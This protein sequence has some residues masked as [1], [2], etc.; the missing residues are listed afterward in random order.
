MTSSGEVVWTALDCDMQAIGL[1]GMMQGLVPASSRPKTGA[2]GLQVAVIDSHALTRECIATSVSSCL[3]G[4]AVVSFSSVLD[5][6]NG[7]I[8]QFGLIIL[9]LHGAEDE[10]LALIRSLRSAHIHSVVFL[11]S[12]H[13]YQINPEFIR[14]AW[15]LGARGFVSAKTTGLTLA[16]SAIRF[17]HAGGFFAPVDDLLSLSPTP[18]FKAAPAP[19]AASE[20]T[21]R[22]TVVLGLLQEGK[23]NKVIA[24]ELLL[25][26]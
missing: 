25:R 12:D 9:Y 16:L 23:T 22:E 6:S 17:V 10:P 21:A 11:I 15:P 18:P 26:A 7:N 2:E 5:C 8:R 19:P 13:D 3:G 20:L 24:R 1:A 14:A 4:I